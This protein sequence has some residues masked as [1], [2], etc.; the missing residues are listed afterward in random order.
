MPERSRKKRALIKLAVAV[1]AALACA[2][3]APPPGGPV[4]EV[5]PKV[6]ETVPRSDS[7]G[8]EATSPIAI[9]FSEDMT[10]TGVERLFG[11]LPEIQIG[12]VSWDGR[13]IFI[14][15]LDPLHPD[16][17]YV[18]RLKSGFRDNHKV[19]QENDHWW[20]FATSAAID[21]GSIS[22]TVYFRREPTRKGVARCFFLPV[23][24][25]FVPQASR[26]DRESAADDAGKYSLRYLPNRR[27]RFIVWAFEDKN[28]NGEFDPNNEYGQTY[29]DTVVLTPS[30]PFGTEINISIVDP[31][32]PATLAGVV[33]DRSG[34]DDSLGVRVTLSPD[35]AD[36]PAYLALCDS[37][38]SYSFKSVTMGRYVLRAFVDVVPDSVCGWFPCWDDTSQQCA[39]PCAVLPDTLAIEPGAEVLADTLYLNPADDRG[40]EVP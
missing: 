36:S 5:P 9:T 34:F 40:G 25:A 6:V 20:A 19:P 26:P 8:V 21:S 29:I 35:T 30:S 2:V 10:R 27:N 22:G 23:D 14:Q 11:M 7:A 13:T 39:E 37:T 28:D 12:K 38:G 16:T 32:E 15:P 4:D 33:V 17:T 1:S 24:S 31:T 18:A 3:E